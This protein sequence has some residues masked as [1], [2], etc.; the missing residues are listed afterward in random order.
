MI[1]DEK[2]PSKKFEKLHLGEYKWL[3]YEEFGKTV[4]CATISCAGTYVVDSSTVIAVTHNLLATLLLRTLPPTPSL[5]PPQIDAAASGFVK[6]TDLKQGAKMVIYAET[7]ADWQA[8]GRLF[9][10]LPSPSCP[11]QHSQL[12]A[13]LLGLCNTSSAPSITTA[14]LPT[15]A[16]QV[17]AQAAFRQGA[18]VVT[19]YATLGEDGVKHG[20]TETKAPLVVCDSKLFKTLV[21]VI[22]QC[23]HVKHI[24][25]IGTLPEDLAK[26][27]PAGI[28]VH[29]LEELI[30]AGKA[31]MVVRGISFN[32]GAHSPDALM[33]FQCSASRLCFAYCNSL[34]G[35]GRFCAHRRLRRPPRRTSP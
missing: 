29:S 27:V 20:I 16:P 10:L 12:L 28:S 1:P 19:I 11:K 4:R 9:P 2:D 21:G 17:A 24:V 30:A 18:V 32:L 13:P 25:T 23:P 22:A 31:E 26:K 5:L 33:S 7:K 15:L 35:C 8:C 3:T 14:A 34:S 6:H